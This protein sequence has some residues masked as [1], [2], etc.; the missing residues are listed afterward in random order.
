[1]CVDVY[2]DIRFS[3]RVVN[4]EALASGCGYLEDSCLII[5]L[6]LSGELKG[7]RFEPA[8]TM[9]MDKID[10]EIT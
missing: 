1:M 2:N 8:K 9:N 4:V 5:S 3:V 6:K 10:K 7:Y